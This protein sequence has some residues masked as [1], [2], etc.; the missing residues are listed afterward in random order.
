M[1]FKRSPDMSGVHPQIAF[2]YLIIEEASQ[3]AMF[4]GA[5][6]SYT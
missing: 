2:N 1:P 3:L 4:Y 5:S 6:A